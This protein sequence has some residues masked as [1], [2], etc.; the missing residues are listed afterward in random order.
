MSDYSSSAESLAH[1]FAHLA[2]TQ[3]LRPGTK[4]YRNARERFIADEFDE[5]FGENTK[6][7]NWQRLYTAV[8]IAGP[9]QSITQ[10]RKVRLM[11]LK[12]DCIIQD[13]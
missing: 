9:P 7:A 10:C 6:L 3:N 2:T 1:N 4:K 11:E 12:S 13:N 5:F 8:G